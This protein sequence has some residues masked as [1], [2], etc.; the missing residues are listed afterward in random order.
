MQ[1]RHYLIA[2]ALFAAGHAHA[3]D[4]DNIQ[5][6]IQS[7]Q[8][9][10]ALERANQSLSANPKDAQ[11]RYLKGISQTELNQL[12]E[13]IRTFSALA[14]DL[15][16]L[17]EPYNNLAVLYA[18]QNQL[19]KARTALL[20][21]IQTNPGYPVAHENLGDIYLRLASQSYEKSLQLGN[22]SDALKGKLKQ[23]L[24][25]QGKPMPPVAA[26]SATR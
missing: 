3:S 26:P 14:N 15:P 25:I 1:V 12:D 21:A 23:A 8:Y 2:L 24:K 4:V 18:R 13:A 19:E 11:L 5:Q 9:G 16:H 17:S 7:K 6:L 22:S 10:Q 20:L